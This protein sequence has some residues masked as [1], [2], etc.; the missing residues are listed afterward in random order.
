[1]AETRITQFGSEHS[2]VW[3]SFVVRPGGVHSKSSMTTGLM[4]MF[5]KNWVVRDDELGAFMVDLAIHGCKVES[6]I[7]NSIIVDR[8]RELLSKHGV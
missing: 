4:S 6:P 2:G 7:L 1:M 5:G 3:E 8:G